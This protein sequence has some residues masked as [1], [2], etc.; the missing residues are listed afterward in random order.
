[1]VKESLIIA[2]TSYFSPKLE[3]NFAIADNFGEQVCNDIV[4]ETI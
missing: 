3:V 4:R 2:F 1:M